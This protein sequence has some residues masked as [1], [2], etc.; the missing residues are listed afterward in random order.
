MAPDGEGCVSV[1]RSMRWRD[2]V[3][4]FA[5]EQPSRKLDGSRLC[6]RL[7]T[8]SRLTV[9]A[10]AR[11]ID[12]QLVTP[13]PDIHSPCRLVGYALRV[14]KMK[15]PSAHTNRLDDGST[16]NSSCPAPHDANLIARITY[17]LAKARRK[18]TQRKRIWRG[19]EATSPAGLGLPVSL[20]AALRSAYATEQTWITTSASQ[21]D[22]WETKSHAEPFFLPL[23]WRCGQRVTVACQS[24]SATELGTFP[25]FLR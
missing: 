21:K 20:G 25:T 13:C 19:L 8:L 12:R 17:R 16:P 6:D 1:R 15:A 24:T 11:S 10:A 9:A 4:P 2:L 23:R 22:R 14:P 3:A 7:F 18:L 5:R